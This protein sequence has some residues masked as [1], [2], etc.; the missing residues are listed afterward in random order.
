MTTT[1]GKQPLTGINVADFSWFAAGPICPQVMGLYGATVVRV[2]SESH[3]DG[4]R[5]I[6]P[7]PPGKMSYNAELLGELGYS[8]EELEALAASGA[9]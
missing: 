4:L 9:V 1:N 5:G 6:G 8:Q 3:M 7:Y 2:E